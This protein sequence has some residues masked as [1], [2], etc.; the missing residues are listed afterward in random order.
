MKRV[1]TLVLALLLLC[2]CAAEQPAASRYPQE[3]SFSEGYINMTLHLPEDW[4]WSTIEPDPDDPSAAYGLQFG[5]AERP[6]A[7][8]LVHE[9]TLPGFCGTGVSFHKKTLANGQEITVA[10]EFR[11]DYGFTWIS[12]SNKFAGQFILY[13][14][15]DGTFWKEQE[16]VLLQILSDAAQKDGYITGPEALE[17]AIQAMGEKQGEEKP[18]RALWVEPDRWVVPCTRADGTDCSVYISPEGKVLEIAEK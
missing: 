1:L 11:N 13:S 14:R 5:P 12:L 4:Q 3:A 2:G 8:E 7:Y 17:L 15:V 18:N 10:S 6:D 9:P 16:P